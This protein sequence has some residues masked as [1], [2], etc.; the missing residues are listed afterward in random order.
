KENIESFLI[1][2]MQSIMCYGMHQDAKRLE[3]LHQ[4][5]D[6]EDE[7]RAKT[8]PT[9]SMEFYRMNTE[10][11]VFEVEFGK[12]QG[13]LHNWLTARMD[14]EELKKGHGTDSVKSVAPRT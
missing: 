1:R 9:P 4:Q 5:P 2:V 14:K 11:R 12:E 3:Q 7:P 6:M 10:Q 8:T 13:D